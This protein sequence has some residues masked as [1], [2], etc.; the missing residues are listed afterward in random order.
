MKAARSSEA[1]R[2]FLEI[3]R[4]VKI[5]ADQATRVSE[6]NRRSC[7]TTLRRDEKNS[8]PAI[9]GAD[10]LVDGSLAKGG[11]GDVIHDQIQATARV[12][13]N[14]ASVALDDAEA[15]LQGRP[16]QR[17]KTAMRPSRYARVSITCW[18]SFPSPP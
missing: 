4:D 1:G 2:G 8:T 6:Q 5:L 10:P 17:R 12:T 15:V 7:R 11:I 9:M 14:L 3:A 16:T 18:R 13:R